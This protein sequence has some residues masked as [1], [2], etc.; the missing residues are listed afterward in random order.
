MSCADP[1]IEL[2]PG[3]ALGCLDETEQISVSEHLAICPACRAK[4]R[5]YQAIVDQLALTV[6]E[7]APPPN[8]KQRLMN[9]IQGISPD[10]D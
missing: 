3:Y 1:I 9:R 6:P 2:L 10:V 8:L 7:A 5:A 4:V